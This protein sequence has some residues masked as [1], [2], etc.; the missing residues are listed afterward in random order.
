MPSAAARAKK[1]HAS[2]QAQAAANEMAGMRQMEPSD[3]NAED[4]AAVRR[5]EAAAARA[6][7]AR[8]TAAEARR[9]ADN[10]FPS[11]PPLSQNDPVYAASNYPP[12]GLGNTRGM[13]AYRMSNRSYFPL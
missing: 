6:A 9:L 10:A 11:L 1:A 3:Y 13:G 2:A 12:P 7:A 4:L 8:A 5:V